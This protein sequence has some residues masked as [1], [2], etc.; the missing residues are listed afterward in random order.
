[1]PKYDKHRPTPVQSSENILKNLP[2]DVRNALN[3]FDVIK[4]FFD[5]YGNDPD[6]IFKKDYVRNVQIRTIYDTL[7]HYTDKKYGD[8]L[9][10]I[11]K[12]SGLSIS[13]IKKI[14]SE[15]KEYKIKYEEQAG[16]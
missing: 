8:I 7:Q 11:S 13:R 12:L 9:K 5:E 10:E 14:L 16:L 6:R 3:D 1:M 4:R 15:F 2:K